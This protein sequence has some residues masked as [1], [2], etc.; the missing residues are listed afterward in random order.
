[1]AD[2]G[3]RGPG[4]A[5][6]GGRCG[7]RGEF[8]DDFVGG[9]AVE[10]AVHG[11]GRTRDPVD[12]RT[13]GMRLQ[14]V[15]DQV[16]ALARIGGATFG[17]GGRGGARAAWTAAIAVEQP[18][19][20]K[21]PFAAGL[22]AAGQ[23]RRADDERAGGEVLLGKGPHVGFRDRLAAAAGPLVGADGDTEHELG[24]QRAPDD[25]ARAGGVALEGAHHEA[26]AGRDQEGH[27]QDP[28]LAR[29]RGV[30]TEG[31]EEQHSRRHTREQHAIGAAPPVA[32]QGHHAGEAEE[33]KNQPHAATRIGQPRPRRRSVARPEAPRVFADEAEIAGPRGGELGTADRN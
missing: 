1:M 5:G 13:L 32:Q 24:G 18:G 31:E 29:P 12:G 10:G 17:D 19:I 20:D 2:A 22:H 33:R 25:E 21:L 28:E 11:G 6:E 15:P 26:G 8:A 14:F 3:R 27:G 16:L 4:R 30:A 9:A 23:G 7:G